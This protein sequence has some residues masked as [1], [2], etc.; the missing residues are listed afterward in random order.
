MTTINIKHF[1]PCRDHSKTTGYV[2]KVKYL[3]SN[4][5]YESLHTDL[6]THSNVPTMQRQI[7]CFCAPRERVYRGMKPNGQEVRKRTKVVKAEGK[8]SYH[9]MLVFELEGFGG[10]LFPKNILK[11][12]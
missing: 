1:T 6:N 4:D 8:S 2:M 5:T 3:C 7:S 11:V 12:T 10:K 9:Y